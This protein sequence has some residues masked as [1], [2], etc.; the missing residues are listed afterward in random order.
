[1]VLREAALRRAVDTFYECALAGTGWEVALHQLARAAGARGGNLICS[2]PSRPIGGFASPDVADVQA[3]YY[4]DSRPPDSR[5]LR[6]RAGPQ[7]GFRSDLHDFSRE[8]LDDDAYYQEFLQPAGLFW[9]AT[10]WLAGDRDFQIDLSLKREPKGSAFEASELASLDA[11][12][13]D[14]RRAARVARR[15]LEAEVEG[16]VQYIHRPGA[17]AFALDAR[18]TVLRTLA[19]EPTA[20]APLA[21]K[22]HRLAGRERQATARIERA[23]G[24][25]LA[26]K[27]PA[28]A[29][30]GPGSHVMILP[31]SGSARDLLGSTSAIAAVMTEAEGNQGEVEGLRS[32]FGLT[33]REASV[34]TLIGAGR[35]VDDIARRLRIGQGTVRNHVKSLYAKT[36]TTRLTEL[37]ALLG[38]LRL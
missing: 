13:P 34:A 16:I 3:S 31:L 36:G 2:L 15:M 5:F 11:V 23:V 8:E 6:V 4:R 1:M 27:R 29:P 28:F 18:G 33:A 35:R 30:L 14:L 26:R 12:L 38:R 21:V 25:A 19:G 10:V 17:L 9:H 24:E 32:A 20:N 7:L 37:V 22:Q